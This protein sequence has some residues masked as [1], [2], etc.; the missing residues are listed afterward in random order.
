MASYTI[1]FKRSAERDLR[2]LPPSLVP[3]IVSRTEALATDPFPR[4]SIKLVSSET[5]YRLRIGVY[6]VIYD[7]DPAARVI[8]VHY[9]RHRRE[10]YRQT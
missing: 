6:R 1:D 8:T 9:I 5:T 2:K 10:A 4:Q 3:A 7:V